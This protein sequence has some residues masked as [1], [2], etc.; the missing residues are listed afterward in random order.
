MIYLIFL[1]P[2]A[3]A[4]LFGLIWFVNLVIGGRSKEEPLVREEWDL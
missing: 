4:L 2:F 3:L 1:I